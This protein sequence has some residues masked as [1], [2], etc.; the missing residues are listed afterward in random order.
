[1]TT[2]EDFQK[3]NQDSM[4]AAVCG[5]TEMNKGFQALGIAV[6]D[7]MRRTAVENT[8]ALERMVAARSVE[9]AMEIQSE[10]VQA[11]YDAYI[12]EASHLGNIYADMAH[13]AYKPFERMLHGVN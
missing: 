2:V 11:A 7:Y 8:A 1:M 5:L 6:V 13:D 4:H 3:L 12:A 9:Q 10:H